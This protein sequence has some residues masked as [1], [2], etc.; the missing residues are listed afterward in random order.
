MKK[1]LFTT[2][3]TSLLLAVFVFAINPI[4]AQ[5]ATKKLKKQNYSASYSSIKKKAKT[6]KKGTTTLK[7]SPSGYVKFKV[8]KT[9]KYTFTFSSVKSNK[10]PFNNGY[11]YIEIPKTQ[12]NGTVYMEH[13]KFKTT[14][15]ETTTAWFHSAKYASTQKT[16]SA[17]IAKRSCKLKLTKGTTV[18]LYVSLAEKGSLK[19]KIK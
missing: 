10:N 6:V 15:G 9:K 14:G 7:V 16:V 17:S 1:T 12:Y 13:Q 2:L 4:P 3:F 8:P 18:Y 19:L 11:A 5:A